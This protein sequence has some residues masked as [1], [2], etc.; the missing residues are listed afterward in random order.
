MIAEPTV[1]PHRREPPDMLAITGTSCRNM[2][3]AAPMLAV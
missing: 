3:S 1:S 2:A